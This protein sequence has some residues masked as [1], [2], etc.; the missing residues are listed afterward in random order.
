[1]AKSPRIKSESVKPPESNAESLKPPQ[2]LSVKP[3]E[4]TGGSARAFEP[5]SVKPPEPTGDSARAFEPAS[6]KPPEPTGDGVSALSVKPPEPIGS[7]KPRQLK[8]KSVKPPEP[9]VAAAK[10]RSVK[11]PEPNVAAAKPKSVKPPEPNVVAAKPKSVK[12]PE[13]VGDGVKSPVL[14][15]RVLLPG[16]EKSPA[17]KAV[18]VKA[19]PSKSKI[20]VSVIVKRKEP[21]KINQ[22]VGRS[23]GPV[24]VTRAEYMKHHAADPSAI[25]LVKAFAKEFNLK[26]EDDPTQTARRTIK[27]TGTAADIQKAFGVSLDQKKIG[28]VEYRVREGGIH[29]PA[30]LT[31]VVEAVLGLD[32]RPQAQPHFRVRTR[33]RAA[34]TAP[35]SYTPP[36]IA[37]AYK[38]PANASGAGQTIGIIELGG[39]YS[40]AD[41]TAYFKSLGLPAPAITTVSVNGGKNAPSKKGGSDGEVM[42]D[43]EVA[44]SVAPGA[45]IVMYFTPNTDQGFADAITTA[46][47]DTTNK[48]SVISISWGGP[49]STWTAQAMTAMDAACQSAAAL[50]VT[51]TVA[52]GDNGS[53]DGIKGANVDFPASSPH[54]LACGGTKLD[55]SGSTIVSE[56]VW[57]ELALKDGATGGG[58]SNFFALPSWQANAKVPAPSGKTG[59][60]GVPDVAGNADPTTG[61]QVRYDGSPTVL[62]GTSAV[63]PLWAGLVAIAN[64]QLGTQVGYLNPIIY[65]AKPAATFNDITVGNNGA[66]SAGPGWDACTGLGS[67][68]AAKL[69]PLLAAP[70]ATAA[71]KPKKAAKTV[72]GKKPARTVRKAGPVKKTAPAKKKATTAK[73]AA[74]AKKSKPV[75]KK[76]GKK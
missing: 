57:N 32:N 9:N 14:R 69:I 21:L 46:I 7:A 61:Y 45:K 76:S 68:N 74:P 2:P 15:A 43:I 64:Q 28:G 49:E 6:V 71:K 47:H 29:L 11:P 59:G 65:T 3:P 60:R 67:P 36:Q 1:M 53:S 51:I 31:G 54:V 5:E 8:P 63:A 52:A 16:S 55:A 73:K 48:P 44:S 23:S 34:T 38:W 18:H 70:S 22:R 33:R 25:K 20:T 35:T 10:P 66:F 56:V 37:Q 24:R 4:P 27:L 50:G 75:K 17:P 30:S 19:T 58:V 26:V 12:P 40:Q 39:G 72:K 62:G 42:L 41:L 13:P